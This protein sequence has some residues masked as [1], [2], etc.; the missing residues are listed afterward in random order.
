MFYNKYDNE[1]KEKVVKEYLSGEKQ[2]LICFEYGIH[3]TQ[4]YHWVAKYKEV[5]TFP[6][7]RG[8]RGKGKNPKLVKVDTSKMTKDEYIAYLEMENDILKYLAS[9]KKKSQK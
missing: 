4:L 8:K 7:G 3:K 5:G 9:L 6:D 1:L 2:S